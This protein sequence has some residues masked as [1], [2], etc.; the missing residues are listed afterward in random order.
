LLGGG[1]LVGALLIDVDPG[2]AVFS[3]SN[4]LLHFLSNL[5]IHCLVS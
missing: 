2:V 5:S 4:F 3:L 1:L